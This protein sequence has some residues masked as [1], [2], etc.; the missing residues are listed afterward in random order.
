MYFDFNFILQSFI[1]KGSLEDDEGESGVCR[2]LEDTRPLGLKNCS[3]KVLAGVTNHALKQPVSAG[4]SKLE[5][6]FI[7]AVLLPVFGRFGPDATTFLFRI[8]R[9]VI[10]ACPISG[11][12]FVVALDPFLQ[13]F[14]HRVCR[15][16]LGVVAACADDIGA[17]LVS[18]TALKVLRPIFEMVRKVAG[19]PLEDSKCVIVPTRSEFSD[20]GCLRYREWLLKNLRSWQNRAF[21]KSRPGAADH[22]WSAPA[23][24][25]RARTFK[26][27]DS[28]LPVAIAVSP[29]TTL[30]PF[31][32]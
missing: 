9:G 17:S 15:T 7:M 24:K 18:M 11:T 19:L 2:C 6:G 1:P 22:G 21:S 27:A 4:A 5:N 25:W 12:A 32:A 26:F 23:R 16:N 30:A 10:Q 3:N 14:E 29:C 8:L 31:R 13:M 20:E 28:K